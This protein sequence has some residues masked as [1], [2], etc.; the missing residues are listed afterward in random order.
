VI[1]LQPGVVVKEETVHLYFEFH[2][3]GLATVIA[4]FLSSLRQPINGSKISSFIG[5]YQTLDLTGIL[6]NA[7][8]HV[9]NIWGHETTSCL[10]GELSS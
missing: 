4:E 1:I 9:I 10:D 2:A 8:V 7:L 6:A 5:C 3:K